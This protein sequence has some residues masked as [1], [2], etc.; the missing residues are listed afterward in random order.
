MKKMIFVFAL[1]FS[2]THSLF[3]QFPSVDKKGW[4]KSM[5]A[6]D[7]SAMLRPIPDKNIFTDPVYNIWCGSVIKAKNGQYYMFYSRWPRSEGH[8]AWVPSSEIAL[9]KASKPQGPYKHVKVVLPR[10][11][12]QYWDGTTTHNPAVVE[13]KGKFY[14]YYMGTTGVKEVQMP[15][16]MKDPNWWEYRNNQRIGVAVADHPEGV[17]QRFDKPVLDVS[18]DSTAF[19]ALMVSNPAI[20]VDQ[21]GRAVLVYKQVERNATLKG[22]KVRFGVAFSNS[23]LGP[24]TKHNKPI[25][26]SDEGETNWMIAEDPFIWNFKGRLYAIVTDVVGLF[27]KKQAA[28]ALLSSTDGIQWQPT[29]HP[30][31]APKFLAFED[32]IISDDKL[33]RPWLLFEK[34]VPTYLFGAHGINKR[35]FSIN[36]AVPLRQPT[37]K[38][39]APVG[40]LNMNKAFGKVAEYSIF[41]NDSLFTWG[42]SPIK[43]KDGKYHIFYSRWHKKYTFN[44]WVTHSEVAHAVADKPLGPYRFSDVALPARGPRF[45]DGHYT[46][47]PTIHLFDGKYYLYYAGNFGDGVNVQNGLNMTHRN[48]Q[49]IGVA[50][51]ESPYGPWTRS[52]K[53]LIDVSPDPDAH[54]ALM[55]ANPSVTRMHDGRYLMVYKAVAK[56]KPMPFGGPVVHLCAVASR[57]DGPFVK[58]N[59][60]IFTVEGSFFPA[61]DPYIWYQDNCYYAIAKDMNGEFTKKGR[62]LVLFY[63]VNGLDWKPAKNALVST[64][65]FTMKNGKKVKLSHMER[66]QLLIE[67][68]VPRA[69]FLACDSLEDGIVKHTFNVHIPLKF[70]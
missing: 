58:M 65:E 68:G 53:P 26:E 20:T 13:H 45:W 49:R 31:V 44:A 24:Y 17:W 42:S 70:K 28:L 32:G 36:V 29:K 69:L 14:L 64:L 8:F 4:L 16:S 51:S 41:E 11:G 48:N 59:K 22:G 47:N 63:S 55:M 21:N 33:E 34:G 12:A 19:D 40:E 3:T 56:R 23:L 15:A 30:H 38:A 54:D 25:F 37:K 46:H 7:I 60:P 1:L 10:R 66:P 5:D 57:P 9:A 39:L 67:K 50:V 2:I 43:G 61:E 6:V 62:S 52:D 18:P 27:T 35:E